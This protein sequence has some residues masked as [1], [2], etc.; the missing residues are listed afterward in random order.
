VSDPGHAER[1]KLADRFDRYSRH[2]LLVIVPIA[3]IAALDLATGWLTGDRL[4][5]VALLGAVALALWGAY[6][7]RRLARRFRAEEIPRADATKHGAFTRL[8]GGDAGTDRQLWLS[9]RRL[10]ASGGSPVGNDRPDGRFG[11]HRDSTR[12]AHHLGKLK[13]GLPSDD[14][15]TSADRLRG[16]G[17]PQR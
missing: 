10:G 11:R 16:A 6:S 8:S 15:G 5:D 2:V 4:I 7:L 1:I 17:L 14:G 12:T 9:D 3:V 13:R